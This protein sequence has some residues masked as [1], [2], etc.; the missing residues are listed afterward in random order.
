METWLG[1]TAMTK[2]MVSLCD[3]KV[4]FDLILCDLWPF[5]QSLT[6]ASQILNPHNNII[7]YTKA[8]YGVELFWCKHLVT[9][10]SYRLR[11]WWMSIGTIILPD[12]MSHDFICKFC[13]VYDLNS[14]E[15]LAGDSKLVQVPT[16]CITLNLDLLMTHCSWH[17]ELPPSSWMASS[18]R[19]RGI[20]LDPMF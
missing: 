14:T 15:T 12:V 9:M 5:E 4:M 19:E 10:S 20:S 3:M 18:F 17:R 16:N 2:A 8:I 7:I 13:G 1:Q 11:W 6:W